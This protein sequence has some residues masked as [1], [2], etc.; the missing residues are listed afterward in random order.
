MERRT[1]LL[2]LFGGLVAATGL[3]AAGAAQALPAT[4]MPV[5]T[6]KA[7]EVADISPEE[8]D[9]LRIEEA[10]YGRRRR[11]AGTGA[12]APTVAVAGGAVSDGLGR[13]GSG[14]PLCRNP[15]LTMCG[16][17]PQR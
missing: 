4:A 1:F 11:C 8:L 14:R 7:P 6:T 10:Q 12:V 2:G 5:R 15:A 9:S 3:A 17:V 13:G 16:H